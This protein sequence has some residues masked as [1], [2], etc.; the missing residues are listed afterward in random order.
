MRE[1]NNITLI[2][3]AAFIPV[4]RIVLALIDSYCNIFLTFLIINWT[5]G[6]YLL[7]NEIKDYFY[8]RE[9]K[10]LTQK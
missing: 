7:K 9:I 4:D 8:A 6:N 1:Q 3:C 2:A 10:N 5:I